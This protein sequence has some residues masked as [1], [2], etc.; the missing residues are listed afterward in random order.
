MTSLIYIQ[1]IK[2]F[3]KK[4]NT[5]ILTIDNKL[6]L[7][8][9]FCNKYSS[10][11][12]EEFLIRYIKEKKTLHLFSEVKKIVLERIGEGCLKNFRLFKKNRMYYHLVKMDLELGKEFCVINY[13][14]NPKKETFITLEKT[15]SRLSRIEDDCDYF[16]QR[17]YQLE[18]EKDGQKLTEFT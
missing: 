11:F 17:Y 10:I 16:Y 15:Y 14:C 8:Q 6:E 9:D 3:I 13:I 4:C 7:L 12:E 1:H 5:R 18:L 2:E